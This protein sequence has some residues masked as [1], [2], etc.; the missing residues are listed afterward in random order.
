MTAL[1]QEP[2]AGG[3]PQSAR[4]SKRT[5]LVEIGHVFESMR[6][7]GY[8][9][10]AA[11]G[12]PV[13]NSIEAAAT[14]IHVRTIRAKDNKS[15]ETVV[16]ADNGKGITPE[17][18]AHAL[19]MGHS[20]RFGGRAGLGRFGVGL[21]LA[22]LSVARRL[23][24]FTR[25]QGSEK[26][27]RAY[28]DLDEVEKGL[29]TYI[30]AIEVD[31]WPEDLAHLMVD[32]PTQPSRGR[33]STPNT[34][35]RPFDSGT[36][37]IWRKV[38]RLKSGGAFGTA[39]DERD[40]ELRK[41][42]ARAYRK[43]LD[44]G[45]RITL[46]DVLITPH[47]PLFQMDNPRIV[48]RYKDLPAKDLKGRIVEQNKLTVGGHEV[49]VVVALVPEIF[50]AR[51]GEG[52]KND[53]AGHDIRD[54]QINEANEG[55]ISILRNG[56]EIYYDIIPRF[57][58]E[59]VVR[60]DRYFA[61]EVSFPAELDEYF[62]VRHVKRGAEPVDKLRKQ[63]RDWVQRP[64]R[65]ARLE[66]RNYWGA[67]ENTE[68]QAARR[69]TDALNASKAAERTA[70]V[71]RA[72]AKMTPAEAAEKVADII[73]D[74]LGDVAETEPER[75]EEIRSSID[76]DALSLFDGGW[77]GSELFEIT[78][79]NGSAVMTL[80]HRHPFFQTFYKP[81]ADIADEKK[82]D[83]DHASL[84]KLARDTETAFD[85]LFLAYAKAENLHADPEAFSDLRTF[86]GSSAR[87]LV[88]EWKSTK[89]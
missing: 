6:D 2:G 24:V 58:P 60:G 43:F 41:F 19:K 82:M 18:L 30:E 77:Q 12:E 53:A 72:G 25:P 46:N 64:V 56:R 65:T 89:G 81:I 55:C 39:L 13:D 38:D 59:G 27:Y 52:G 34:A 87:S 50:R 20:T 16:I 11:I 28:I 45:L 40:A 5:D 62:Q 9:L 4:Q 8:D 10:T 14:T 78:H 61:V 17:G 49:N 67:V 22:T 23:E 51:R 66:I 88:N 73:Q 32:A 42:V 33:V 54:M 69:H 79:L 35:G 31:G 63:L 74:V 83:L 71:G 85:L 26:Y 76:N 29:Q 21:K 7:A 57:L 37:V 86:W 75:A 47:D 1:F 84:V 70:P 80:N 3:A 44:K 48:E 68:R 36:L 15:V